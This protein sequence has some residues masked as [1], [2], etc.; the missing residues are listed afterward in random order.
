[1]GRRRK[2]D[3]HL[4]ERVYIKHGAYY[5]VFPDGKW[6][7][8]AKVGEEAEMRRQW[9][10]LEDPA[11]DSELTKTMINQ[12]L[13]EYARNEKSKRSYQ[14][15]CKEAE[16]LNAFF[17]EMRPENVLPLHV[18]QYLD[19]NLERKVRANREVALLSSVY[20]WALRHRKWGYVVQVNPCR[21]VKRHT[22]TK[23]IRI[24]TD[25]E[26]SAV[27]NAA[28][29]SVQQ[30]MTFQYRTLQRPSDIIKWGPANIKA[31]KHQGE[32]HRTIN[33]EQGKGGVDMK[34]IITPDIE[35]AMQ[36]KT[37]IV[38]PTFIHNRLGKQ[39]TYSGINSNFRRVMERE[40]KKIAKRNGEEY[41]P[42]GIYDLKGKGATDMYRAGVPMEKIQVLCGH[43][44]I[45]TTEIYIKSRLL[46]PVMPNQVNNT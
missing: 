32:Q 37:N 27:F 40:V 21:G 25:E 30:I 9:A 14:D 44:S 39:Y 46:D 12:Y 23:R 36:P 13:A 26:Y 41:K 45:T 34:I 29:R 7:R 5:F 16:Y 35:A 24:V 6:H 4:P 18:D 31:T 33:L 15:N 3:N 8:L 2:S 19:S 22:E 28:S 17:G 20:S 10:A 42:F 43:E 38:Y 1:M 11:E